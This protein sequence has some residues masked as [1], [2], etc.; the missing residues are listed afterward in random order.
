MQKTARGWA[1]FLL[2]ILL[3]LSPLPA[4]GD[5]EE[6]TPPPIPMILDN[7]VT[8]TLSTRE[9][10]APDGEILTLSVLIE[11]PSSYILR[12]CSLFLGELPPGVTFVPG[13]LVISAVPYPGLTPNGSHLGNVS[14]YHSV[15][16]TFQ[17]QVSS[18]APAGSYE[19]VAG[20]DGH[21]QA[22]DFQK[23]EVHGRNYETLTI[24]RPLSLTDDGSE[25]E[26]PMGSPAVHQYAV[27]PQ[28]L[29]GPDG[30]FS[31]AELKLQVVL[32]E[33]N[34]ITLD[35]SL[36]LDGEESD[37]PVPVVSEE[38][39]EGEFLDLS[40]FL[41]NGRLTPFTFSYE[42]DTSQSPLHRT[43][44]PAKDTV[45]SQPVLYYRLVGEDFFRTASL[46]TTT[47]L[48]NRKTFSYQWSSGGQSHHFSVS[49]HVRDIENF[50]VEP[51]WAQGELYQK[52]SQYAATS[53]R[54]VDALCKAS[55]R[56]EEE[57]VTL[58]PYT[59]SFFNLKV[60]DGTYASIL[61]LREDGSIGERPA[62]V[63]DG[64]VSSDFE[65]L[66]T[67]ALALPDENYGKIPEYEILASTGSGGTIQ[68][69]GI[70]R[71]SQGSSA[72]FLIKPSRGYRVEKLLVDGKSLPP[73]ESYL[74][75]NISR[76]H[77]IHV[78]FTK[79][80]PSKAPESPVNLPPST[81]PWAAGGAA[82]AA[83]AALL[84]WKVRKG[85][86]SGRQ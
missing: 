37:L 20:L 71:L 47:H 28:S 25:E 11:N 67:F 2:A 49:S 48:R 26:A 73:A 40:Q 65:A 23:G 78:V 8:V 59:V 52:F 79:I 63:T 80:N 60:E 17:L 72:E 15:G 74:F 61:Y 36:T 44:L 41:H 12:N 70:S 32:P 19:I 24:Y 62:K 84:V 69:S 9:L 13:S 4:F 33:D 14:V 27:E 83:A 10:T 43:L 46:T 3:I 7:N 57:P 56:D 54:E 6:N 18:Q 55:I 21:Y 82:L 75:E 51:I 68:P 81:L 38:D 86:R 42:L 85:K 66:T 39:P 29:S 22:R 77:E 58:S 34:R 64:Q 53:S 45:T 16:A 35:S 30:A 31:F 5:A 1:F 76:D 50:V